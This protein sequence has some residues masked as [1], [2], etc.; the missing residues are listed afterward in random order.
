MGEHPSLAWFSLGGCFDAQTCSRAGAAETPGAGLPGRIRVFP[1]RCLRALAAHDPSSPEALSR[2]GPDGLDPGISR[3]PAPGSCPS[4]DD[5]SG[6]PRLSTRSPD[7]G[8]GVDP[9]D[10]RRGPTPGRLAQLVNDPPMVPGRRTGPRPGRSAAAGGF[11]TGRAT[12]SDL[13][14]RCLR[15]H[16]PGRRDRSLLASD[17][18]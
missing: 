14:D 13:A 17:L 7:L 2:A 1:G 5:P 16:P 6:R 18:G 4:R 8:R 11:H 10:A 12:A 3:P 9:R 15:A